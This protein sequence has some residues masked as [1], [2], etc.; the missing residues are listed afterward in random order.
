MQNNGYIRLKTLHCMQCGSGMKLRKDIDEQYKTLSIP[1]YQCTNTACNW[2]F[3]NNPIPV[4]AAI[5]EYT[6]SSSSNPPPI[7]R[8]ED[9]QILL[10]RGK[11]WPAA[12]FGLVTGFLGRTLAVI[13]RSYIIL[14]AYT[15]HFCIVCVF[16]L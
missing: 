6:P 2:L 8:N 7:I 5:I 14:Y 1:H 9:R 13:Y 12:W 15:H 11:N 4:V 10:V 16:L 3:Y